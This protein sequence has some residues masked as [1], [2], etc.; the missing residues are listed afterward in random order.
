[1][2]V[3]TED[4]YLCSLSKGD[5]FVPSMVKPSFHPQEL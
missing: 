5:F 4:S 1:M 3:G 2:T